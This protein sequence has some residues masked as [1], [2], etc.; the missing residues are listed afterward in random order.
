[1]KQSVA[2]H[3]Q[4]HK[5]V[6]SREIIKRM[7]LLCLFYWIDCEKSYKILYEKLKAKSPVIKKVLM[8]G[9]HGIETHSLLN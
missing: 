7:A 8:A 1:M 2:R 6:R 5:I 3:L 9:Y 4:V